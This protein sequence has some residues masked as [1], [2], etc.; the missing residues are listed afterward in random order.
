MIVERKGSQT[1][2]SSQPRTTQG[3]QASAIPSGESKIPE[4]LVA[5]TLRLE[6]LMTCTSLDIRLVT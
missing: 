5:V 4:S 6:L 1:R 3:T 2:A